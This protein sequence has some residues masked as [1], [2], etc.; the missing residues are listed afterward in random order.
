MGVELVGFEVVACTLSL[1]QPGG[2]GCECDTAAGLTCVPRT[3]GGDE[4]MCA[5]VDP[6]CGA[7]TSLFEPSDLDAGPIPEDKRCNLTDH[8]VC[9][10]TLLDGLSTP[11]FVGCL[12]P[13]GINDLNEG[14]CLIVCSSPDLDINGNQILSAEEL[15]RSYD[16]PAG[17]TCSLELS[18]ALG[19]GPDFVEQRPCDPA[20]C[21]AGLP[22]PEQ[23]GAGDVECVTI[24]GESRCIA[25]Y[26]TCVPS[27]V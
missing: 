10:E 2:S 21:T 7:P 26:G 4:G 5:R 14:V 25:L 19:V 23:C 27:G 11:G 22:C 9:D 24:A 1:C 16:C 15:G 6:V 20:S 13:P 18:R 8:R 17:Y 3:Y 12:H